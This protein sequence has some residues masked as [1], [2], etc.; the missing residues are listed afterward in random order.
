MSGDGGNRGARRGGAT[1]AALALVVVAGLALVF[2]LARRAEAGRPAASAGY[3]DELSVSPEAA[4]RMSLAFNGLAADWY[5]LRSI[6]YVGRKLEEYPG[7][8]NIDDLRPIGATQLAPML[9]RVTSL[10]PQF[11]AAYEYGAIVLP[12][13]D[14]DA[15]VRLVEKGIKA[16]PTR[17]RFYHQLGYIHWHAGRYAEA[18]RAYRDGS[19][20]K[21]APAWMGVMA[22]QME[23]RGGSR[24]FAREIYRGMYDESGDEQVRQ[25]AL[26]RLLQLDSLDLTDFIKRVLDE[27]RA[28]AGRCPASWREVAPALRAARVRL[29]EAGAPLDPT[30]VPYALD[31]AACAAKL[32]ENS[33]IP[34]E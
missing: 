6:Q 18:A 11:T 31:T 34:R 15:A 4:R 13:I 19:A 17:W 9:E 33:E 5:W 10:D 28:R 7:K 27:Q 24:D 12:A 23:A 29:D 25:L 8:I 30:G 21:G 3:Q 26:R 1:D 16:N 14:N 20:V 22:A 2:V 32:G